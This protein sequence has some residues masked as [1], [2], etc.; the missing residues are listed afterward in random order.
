[1]KKSILSIFILFALLLSSCG[2]NNVNNAIV[3]SAP[4][5]NSES[6]Y[7]FYSNIWAYGLTEDDVKGLPPTVETIERSEA[8]RTLTIEFNGKNYTG[9]YLESLNRQN[10]GDWFDYYEGEDSIFGVNY[11]TGRICQFSLKSNNY[12][13]DEEQT[14][15][16]SEEVLRRR[17]EVFLFGY[18]EDFSEY[19]LID[20]AYRSHKNIYYYLYNRTINGIKTSDEIEIGITASGVIDDYGEVSPGHMENFELPSSEEMTLLDKEFEDFMAYAYEDYVY[21]YECE[22]DDTTFERLYDGK[23]A[24]IYHIT[25]KVRETESDEIQSHCI[26]YRVFAY[27]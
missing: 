7:K 14:E 21:D 5:E 8:P 27:V 24:I 1:M 6:K 3:T 17:V 13:N 25:V 12:S 4:L 22:V 23:Y 18:L 11:I 2:S 20:T 9:D 10:Y 26:H 19:T 16:F 15:R